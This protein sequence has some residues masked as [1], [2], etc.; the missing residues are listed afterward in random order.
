MIDL[1]A[2]PSLRESLEA[3]G[4]LANKGLGQHFLLD[5]RGGP[6]FYLHGRTPSHGR[7]EHR[8]TPRNVDERPELR[9]DR[10]LRARLL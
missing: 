2:L 6:L 5:L 8:I 10:A 1:S 9:E 4:L 3:H 7:H